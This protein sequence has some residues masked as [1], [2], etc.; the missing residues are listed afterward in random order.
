[1]NNKV[2]L[3]IRAEDRDPT[4]RLIKA[5][6][7]RRANSLLKQF[8]QLLTVQM[9]QANQTIKDTTGVDRDTPAATGQ[10][11]AALPAGTTNRGIIIGTGTNPVTMTDYN[12]QTQ[13]TT[14]ITH[15]AVTVS[16]ENPDAN[17]W[18]VAIQRTFTNN[19]GSTLQV[20]E[21]G[22]AVSGGAAAWPMLCDR[23]LYSVDIPNGSAKTFTYRLTVSL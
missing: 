22:L 3:Q 15:S 12:L 20:R 21:V 4:G 10:F 2:Y 17:T 19:T 9:A 13:V 14:N 11:Q 16:A 8:I 7:W 18:R 6:P 23:T 1:M 5:Y